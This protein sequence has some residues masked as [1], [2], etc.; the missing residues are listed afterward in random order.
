MENRKRFTRMPLKGEMMVGGYA[1]E[2]SMLRQ[3]L[4]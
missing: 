4:E 3:G 1:K 2:H